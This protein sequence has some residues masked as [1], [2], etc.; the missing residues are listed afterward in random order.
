M[1]ILS[2]QAVDAEIINS[3]GVVTSRF[4]RDDDCFRQIDSERAAHMAPRMVGERRLFKWDVPVYLT[5][6]L[7]AQ[8]WQTVIQF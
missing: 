2:S 3:L 1:I 4:S 5:L 8:Q 7:R 6:V